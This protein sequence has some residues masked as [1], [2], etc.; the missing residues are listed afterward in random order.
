SSS[1]AF[2][3]AATVAVRRRPEISAIS[4]KNSPRD[5]RTISPP[6]PTWMPTSPSRIEYSELAKSLRRNTMSPAAQL[7]SVEWIRNSRICSGVSEENSGSRS[8]I[9]AISSPTLMSRLA[10]LGLEQRLVGRRDRVALDVFDDLVALV[11]AV[12]DQ[13]IAGERTDDVKPL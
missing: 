9:A 13:R 8:R 6:G 3:V 12:L 7:C 2:L 1:T 5:R 11:E 4:P 10:Q